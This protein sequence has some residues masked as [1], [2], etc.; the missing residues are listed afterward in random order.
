[1]E[2]IPTAAEG[3]A[4]CPIPFINCKPRDRR[5]PNRA[6]ARGGHLALVVTEAVDLVGLRVQLRRTARA[7]PRSTAR[8]GRSLRA[9]TLLTS[10]IQHWAE[11]QMSMPDD[12]DDRG[13]VGRGKSAAALLELLR[14]RT[15]I[16]ALWS[17]RVV[18]LDPAC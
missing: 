17:L 3:H 12:L 4:A 14:F 6:P 13:E 8:D 16:P 10:A 18:P 15:E 2:S 5:P 1:M 9:E 7:S 11:A